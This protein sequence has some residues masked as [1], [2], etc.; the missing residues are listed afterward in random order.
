MGQ[1]SLQTPP[2]LIA[3][4]VTD[5]GT[6][7]AGDII[8][9]RSA[10][11]SATCFFGACVGW[12]TAERLVINLAT[13]QAVR[14][15]AGIVAW[16]KFV[17]RSFDGDI[18]ESDGNGYLP[19]VMFDLVRRGRI[20]VFCEG[21]VAMGDAVH[22]RIDGTNGTTKLVG[23]FLTAKDTTHT[24]DVTPFCSW[25]GATSGAGIAELDVNFINAAL[26][27]ADS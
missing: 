5:L 26:A 4:M 27:T 11:A 13:G 18:A 9:V 15:L 21:A 22:V 10:E 1:T 24:L 14:K 25:V 16:H 23:Q 2:E 17:K 19:D 7:L 12:S 6:E 20:T 3:G 8:S